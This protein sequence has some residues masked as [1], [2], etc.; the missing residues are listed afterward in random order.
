[1]EIEEIKNL[2]KEQKTRDIE[3]KST[4]YYTSLLDGLKKNEKKVKR[5]YIIMSI[6]M[7]FTIF[8]IDKVAVESMTDKTMLTWAGFWMIYLAIAAI[9]YV[10]W[11]TVIKFDVKGLT[12]SSL[13][14][15]KT[16]REKL[17]LRNRLR[18]I[19]IPVYTALLTIGI[20]FVYIQVTAPMELIYKVIT[21]TLFY[22]FMAIIT[23]FSYKREKKKYLNE[24]KPIEDKLDTLLNEH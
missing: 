11:A 15:L 23:V 18:T 7:L 21:Y 14:F 6:V 1:M 4:Q 5:N 16:A 9:I 24:V 13:E 17:R 10:S 8:F 20:T 2:W 12:E 22:L 19:G 3:I